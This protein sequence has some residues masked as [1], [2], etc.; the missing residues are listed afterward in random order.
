MTAVIPRMDFTI[1]ARV[2]PREIDRP[3]RRFGVNN[4]FGSPA[5]LNRIGRELGNKS[6]RGSHPNDGQDP[7]QPWPTLRRVL[8]AGAPVSPI[9]LERLVKRL[10]T[11]AQI[12][13]PYGATESLPVAI[14]GSDEILRDTRFLTGKGAGTCVGRPVDGVEVQII[15]ISDEPI[16]EWHDPL[17]PLSTCWR[18]WR[19]RCSR[20]DGDSSQVFFTSAL[21]SH[22]AFKQKST[23]RR[24]VE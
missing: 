22:V 24:Q 20:T 15:R 7:V 2:D 13:T 18:N 17:R 9:I 3:I 6:G 23:T 8:S 4:L 1:P 10:P 16:S 21:I 12:F 11:G 5:L 14:I 19:N